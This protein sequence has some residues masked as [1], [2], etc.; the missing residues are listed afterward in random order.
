MSQPN[1]RANFLQM[2][3][4][5]AV[6][7]LGI[8]LWMSSQ[9]KP[10][11]RPSDQIIQEMKKLNLEI[12]DLSIARMNS[13]L[14]TKVDDEV[15]KKQITKEE[16]NRR[17]THGQVLTAVT[18]YRAGV[19][20]S[21]FG[22]LN[23]AYQTL[24][25]AERTRTSDPLWTQ[26]EYEVAVHP[27]FPDKTFVPTKLYG[28]VV[29]KLSERSKSDLIM[30]VVPGYQLIDF[31]VHL[32]GAV[33]AFSYAFAA[34][35]LAFI[36]RAAVFPLAQKQYMFGRQMA[37]LSPLVN[38]L[39]E[40]YTDKKTKQVTN[41]QELQVKTME[42]YR[43]YGVNPMAGCGPALI[44]IP[45]FLLIYQCMVHYQFDFKKGT[46]LWI[47]PSLSANT[48]GFI[49]PNLGE[50]DYILIGIYAISMIVTT[51]LTPVSDPSNVKQQRLMG[52]SVAVI[53]SVMMFFWPLPSA[54]VLYWV[55]T[56][57]F[58]TFHMLYAYRQ[59]LPP[60]QKK[61]SGAGGLFPVDVTASGT[62]GAARKTGTPVRHRAKKKK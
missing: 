49:A 40:R 17:K 3:M 7:F 22:R 54:F 50:R 58:A 46:F 1:P 6:I 35:L 15:N 2:L 10:D 47:N 13:T 52:V 33:P 12:K 25:N 5:T 61:M 38:E 39:K 43:E 41:P 48:G 57:V 18:Q 11:V 4:F 60:L 20:R 19:Q 59:P 42:L 9:P 27:Q 32:T 24:H 30:G 37:Q 23:T 31:L 8:Q 55:F 53:F 45:F 56:N 29:E 16:G 34:L 28:Q 14:A 36:V 21:D 26:T 62:N 51:L 44:Q